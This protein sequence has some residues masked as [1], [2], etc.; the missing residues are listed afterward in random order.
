MNWERVDVQFHDSS[1][2]LRDTMDVMEERERHGEFDSS[3]KVRNTIV[4][5]RE[6]ADKA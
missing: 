3:Q 4:V 1:R 6:I 5:S 2:G